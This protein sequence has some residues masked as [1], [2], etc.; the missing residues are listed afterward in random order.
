MSRV[1]TDA[2][3]LAEA[4]LPGER[5]LRPPRRADVESALE[6]LRGLRPLDAHDE[7][8]IGEAAEV[9]LRLRDVAAD[10]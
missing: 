4:L 2:R 6:A 9:L 1:A 5:D 10:R 7:I 3:R 8:A